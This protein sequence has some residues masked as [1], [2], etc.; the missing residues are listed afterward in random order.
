MPTSTVAYGTW[1]REPRKT[2][3]GASAGGAAIATLTRS[4]TPRKSVATYLS[5]W[6]TEKKPYGFIQP[7]ASS[8]F[9][10][11][12]SNSD[13]FFRAG[14]VPRGER[15]GRSPSGI[16]SEMQACLRQGALYNLSPM[17]S[18]NFITN[19]YKSIHL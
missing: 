12:D 18:V 11:R 16:F 3:M 8:G 5:P 14:D 6:Y 10:N 4:S 19:A 13:I 2:I 15:K 17:V 7:L 1:S 9:H